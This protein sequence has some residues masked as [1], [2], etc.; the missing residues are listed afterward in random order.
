MSLCHQLL[1]RLLKSARPEDLETANRLIKSTIKEVRRAVEVIFA[2]LPFVRFGFHLCVC[3]FVFQEQEKAEKVSKREST[4]KEVESS[5]KQLRDLLEQHTITGT[6]LGPSGDVKV[7]WTW[8]SHTWFTWFHTWG[9]FE[10]PVFVFLLSPSAG[11]LQ[12]CL[13]LH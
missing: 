6:S 11:P 8:Y 12:S 7:C 10:S 5:T 2:L 3:V 9:L 4:L 13:R 1:A